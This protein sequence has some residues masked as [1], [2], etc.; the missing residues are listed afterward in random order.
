MREIGRMERDMIEVYSLESRRGIPAAVLEKDILLTDVLQAI[1]EIRPRGFSLAFCGGT[2]LA[3]AYKV[4]DR[5]SEDLDFKVTVPTCSEKQLLSSLETSRAQIRA[6]VERIGFPGDDCRAY[7]NNRFFTF[8]LRYNS[9]FKSQ[10]ESLR[11][12]IQVECINIAPVEKPQLKPM[13]SI[14]ADHFDV[15]KA[16]ELP[17]TTLR[18]TL[19]EKTVALLRRLGDDRER[20]RHNPYLMRHVYDLSRI[21]QNI[22]RP[23]DAKFQEMFVQK[24]RLDTC[25]Y[26]GI[27][28]AFGADAKKAMEASVMDLRKD[29]RHARDYETLLK[30]LV[31]HGGTSSYHTA[32]AHF[33]PLAD[34]LIKRLD[35]ADAAAGLPHASWV[36]PRH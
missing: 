13:R 17:C 3:K 21:I 25:Q 8:R 26:A 36:R 32:L 2:A 10:S 15:G 1:S 24:V 5:M 22:G 20:N 34:A 9:R 18:E 4:I 14:V 27:S 11:P 35:L 12:Y 23:D 16:V 31:L 6:A 30:D 28:A 7:N 33:L 19:V 29:P